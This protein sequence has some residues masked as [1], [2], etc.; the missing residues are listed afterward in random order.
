M[1]CDMSVT[2]ELKVLHDQLLAAKPE[3]AQHEE[4]TCPFCAAGADATHDTNSGGSMPESFTQAELDAAVAAASADLQKRLEELGAQVRDTEV[5][6][7]VAE[8]VAAKETEVS[9]LQNKLDAAEAARTAAENKLSETEKYWAET[10]AAAE[11]AAQVAAR[12]DE[13]VAE[14]KKAGVLADAYVDE[15]A[16]RFA[17]MSDEDFTARLDEW[18]AIAAAAGTKTGDIPAKTALA[19]ARATDE[20]PTSALSFIADLRRDRVDPKSLIGGA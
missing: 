9:E 7:A 8:A 15:N 18:K 10:I 11:D 1:T 17:A 2:P 3:E 13:R 12:R 19:A 14:A 5:G 4:A 16:D 6:Q 20:Q